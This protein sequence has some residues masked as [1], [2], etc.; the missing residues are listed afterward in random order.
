MERGRA[1]S[2]GLDAARSLARSLALPDVI[3]VVVLLLKA[4]SINAKQDLDEVEMEGARCH[5][6][7]NVVSRRPLPRA[8]RVRKGEG[9]GRLGERLLDRSATAEGTGTDGSNDSEHEAEDDPADPGESGERLGRVAVG[10]GVRLGAAAERAAGAVG[11]GSGTGEPE[12][13]G[14]E[15]GDTVTG[16]RG[17]DAADASKEETGVDHTD[18]ETPPAGK[19]EETGSVV[20][21]L[22]WGVVVAVVVRNEHRSDDGNDEGHH[23]ERDEGDGVSPAD[24]SGRVG[25]HDC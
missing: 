5:D 21:A 17:D 10:E 7:R 22:G 20:D 16:D 13:P 4:R 25:S 23:G 11:E 6:G 9:V 18:E 1:R 8:D 12:D 24:E 19:E 3:I 14:D 15:D 2:M